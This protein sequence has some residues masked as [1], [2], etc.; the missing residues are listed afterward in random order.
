MSAPIDLARTGFADGEAYDRAR[1]GYPHDAVRALVT[2]CG[3]GPGARV[4]DLAAGSG[5]LTT[6]LV[7]TGARVVAVEPTDGM[8]GMLQRHP[9]ID[10]RAGRAEAIPCADAAM[11]AV[12]VAQAFHWFDGPAALG[13]IARVLRPGGA[14]GL[15]WNVMDRDVTWVDRLQSLIHTR[16]GRNPWYAGHAWRAAFDGDARFTPLD[17]RSFRNA[18]IVDLAGLRGRVASV[19]FIAAMKAGERA[20]LLDEVDAIARAE[21]LDPARIPIPYRTDVFWC[22]STGG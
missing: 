2:A 15:L 17:E 12:T 20:R 5:K 14:L 19:S 9:G 7:A 6:H 10:V 18:Q 8:R 16:R 22:R 21:G 11:D 3:V 4:L 1:P 13:E